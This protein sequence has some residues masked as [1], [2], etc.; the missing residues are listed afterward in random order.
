M[1]TRIIYLLNHYIQ[2]HRNFQERD[3]LQCL[4]SALTL[5]GTIW[6]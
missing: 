4:D 2:K 1:K 5:L 6:K 3:A